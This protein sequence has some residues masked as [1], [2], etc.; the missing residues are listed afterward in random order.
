[1]DADTAYSAGATGTNIR[2][3]DCEYGWEDT[4]EDLVD[5]N[6]NLESG[7][8]IPSWVASYGWDSHGTAAIGETFGYRVTVPATP[9]PFP[10]YDVRI[11]DDLTASAADLSFVGVTKIEGSGSWTPVNTGTDTSLVIEDPVNGIDIPAGEQAVFEITVRL[12]DTATNVAGLTF[13]N[14]AAYTYN[15]IDGDVITERPGDPGTSGLMTIVEPELTLEKG[16][17]VNMT[18]GDP[19]SF[20]LNVHNIGDS[21][22]WNLSNRGPSAGS[23]WALVSRYSM[24]AAPVSSPYCS[25]DRRCSRVVRGKLSKIVNASLLANQSSLKWEPGLY[26][27]AT[28]SKGR[29]GPSSRSVCRRMASTIWSTGTSS[30]VPR[31]LR[32]SMKRAP[33]A[34]TPFC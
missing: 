10:L 26:P 29:I 13:T 34:R 20:S 1:M 19:G 33:S 18:A 2:L 4:H 15:I 5:R 28:R 24:R 27:A 21:P 32:Y 8:T 23:S 7:Q 22:A 25:G 3:S 31:S 9:Y 16:G 11:V 30:K 17:P 6:L 14:T 12:Q